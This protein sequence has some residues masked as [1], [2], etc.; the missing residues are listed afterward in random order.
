MKLVNIAVEKFSFREKL[1]FITNSSKYDKLTYKVW[2]I[3]KLVV[4]FGN[5]KLPITHSSCNAILSNNDTNKCIFSRRIQQI[6]DDVA[7]NMDV[8]VANA[9]RYSDSFVASGSDDSQTVKENII[10]K[11]NERITEYTLPLFG[12]LCEKNNSVEED[13][14]IEK[15]Y[16]HVGRIINLLEGAYGDIP[17][18]DSE[19]F[20]DYLY[21]SVL[22]AVNAIFSSA[23]IEIEIDEMLNI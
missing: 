18:S 3:C 13:N 14:R 17:Y 11:I 12:V 22:N 20:K 6:I 19:M 1:S 2:T 4:S 21:I 9:K 8:K 7:K 15:V 23:E 16:Y 5:S 10:F